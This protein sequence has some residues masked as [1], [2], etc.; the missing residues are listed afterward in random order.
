MQIARFA[1]VGVS[2]TLLSYVVY[3]ALLHAQMPYVV[4]AAAAFSAGAVNGYALNRRWTFAAPDSHH[5]RLSY[6][7]VQAFALCVSSF[8][9]WLVVRGAGVPR[10]AAYAVVLPP[11]TLASFAANRAWTFRTTDE[12]KQLQAPPA[13]TSA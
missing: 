3:V 11:I 7:V 6:L 5:A 9:V 12:R 1:I 4:A 8:S 2:N 10:F 13:S